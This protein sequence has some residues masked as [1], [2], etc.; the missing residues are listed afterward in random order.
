MTTSDHWA[1]WGTGEM[2]GGGPPVGPV[3]VGVIAVCLGV[4]AILLLASV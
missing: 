4:L 3:L 2:V 1:P